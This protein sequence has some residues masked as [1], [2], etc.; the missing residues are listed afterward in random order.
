MNGGGTRNTRDAHFTVADV[1]FFSCFF[2]CFLIIT[3]AIMK[4]P[5]LTYIGGSNEIV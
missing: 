4:K 1:L 3:I 5:I 2:M